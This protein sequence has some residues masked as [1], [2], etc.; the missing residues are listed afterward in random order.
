MSSFGPLTPSLSVVLP[1]DPTLVVGWF[2]PSS[3]LVPYAD[4][5]RRVF[6]HGLETTKF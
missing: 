2:Y 6:I 4:G 1:D 3:H 5:Q